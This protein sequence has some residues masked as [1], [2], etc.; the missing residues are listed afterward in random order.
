MLALLVL[1]PAGLELNGSVA[2]RA[3]ATVPSEDSLLSTRDMPILQ[4]LTELNGQV[5]GSLLDDKLRL[6][7]DA[8]AFLTAQGG[9]ADRDLD[10]GEMVAVDSDEQVEPPDPFVTLSEWWL[11]AEPIPHL[12]L[13]VG[14]KRTV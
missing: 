6:G 9:Y 13:T 8:S 10:S 1:L 2:E 4:S 5:R 14:K 12:M 7:V 3:Q 11:S